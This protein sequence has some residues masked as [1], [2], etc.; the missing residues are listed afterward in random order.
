LDYEQ[1]LET[2]A[3]TK[4]SGLTPQDTPISSEKPVSASSSDIETEPGGKRNGTSTPQDELSLE[5][6]FQTAAS[7]PHGLT[8]FEGKGNTLSREKQ[9]GGEKSLTYKLRRQN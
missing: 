4:G 3:A 7:Q 8:S 5:D 9:A 1:P 6:K 2:E